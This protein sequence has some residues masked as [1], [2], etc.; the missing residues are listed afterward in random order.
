[1][2]S[3]YFIYICMLIIS[4]SKVLISML[5]LL[6]ARVNTMTWAGGLCLCC[7]VAKENLT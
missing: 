7:T 3:K 4:L 6:E 2:Y 5:L 1:M